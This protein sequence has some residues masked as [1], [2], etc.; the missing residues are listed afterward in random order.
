MTY[1]TVF[2]AADL[3]ST[4]WSAPALGMIFVVLG[5][6]LVFE[7]AF[8]QRVLPRP[9]PLRTLMIVGWFVLIFALLWTAGGFVVA[10][11]GYWI[12][13]DNLRHGR[14][15]VVEGPVTNFV[16]MPRGGHHNE[17]FSVQDRRFTYSDYTVTAGFN[18][19]ASHG[20]PIRE[21]LYVR[22]TYS[23]NLILRLEIAQ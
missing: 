12:V 10:Y 9:V 3:G 21:G 14:Y 7:K 5:A 8:M 16:P 1:R 19:S 20:G 11:R 23:G 4:D 18:N 15:N 6:L 22:I 2:D 17:S 13:A